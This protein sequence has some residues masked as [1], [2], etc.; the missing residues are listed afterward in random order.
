M[1]LADDQ[2][3]VQDLAAQGADKALADRVPARCLDGGAQDPGARS[4][5]DGVKGA[6]EI[7]PAA[8]DQEPG[9][10]GPL[11]GA[12][13]QVAG[14]LHGPLARGVRGDATEVHPPGAV[15]DNHQDSVES[16]L[17]WLSP[18]AVCWDVMITNEWPAGSTFKQQRG[19]AGQMET[20]RMSALRSSGS[21]SITRP[22]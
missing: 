1:S 13:G 10:P 7:R 16:G 5:E 3:P 6:G 9:V 4:L 8:A 20:A 21:R 14:L 22:L 17:S 19:G 12:E 15:L 18:F 2:H 11:A